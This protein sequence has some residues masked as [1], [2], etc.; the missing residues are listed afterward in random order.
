MSSLDTNILIY[1]VNSG[2]AEH[3]SAKRIY[4]SMLDQPT[5]WIIS[6]QVLFEFYRALRNGK[7]LER[8]LDHQRALR[9]IV[10]LREDSG[11]QHCS[12]EPS[13]WNDLIQGFAGAPPK[14]SHIFDRVLGVTLQQHGVARFYTRNTK[15]FADFGFKELIN[16]IDDAA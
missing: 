9:Q 6:D 5:Q 12:Y 11:V 4:E 14:P 2:C 16:P 8:P 15:D 3:A 10:F 7:I 13:F 1:A